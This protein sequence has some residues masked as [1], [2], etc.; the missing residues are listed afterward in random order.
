M[1]HFNGVKKRQHKIHTFFQKK[2]KVESE[3]NSD[4]QVSI[5][6]NVTQVNFSF[7]LQKYSLSIFLFYCFDRV[8]MIPILKIYLL[9]LIYQ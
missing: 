9:S 2:L 8:T 5:M 3:K 7:F 1:D 4:V 6:I